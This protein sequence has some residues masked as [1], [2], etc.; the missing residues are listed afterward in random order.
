MERFRLACISHVGPT[1]AHDARF[2]KNR[3]T[4]EF[5]RGHSRH[6][7]HDPRPDDDRPDHP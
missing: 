3:V 6:T 2:A 5:V 1:A 7:L 4:L